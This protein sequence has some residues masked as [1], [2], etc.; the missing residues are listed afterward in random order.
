MFEALE[1][2]AASKSV[3]GD[4]ARAALKLAIGEDNA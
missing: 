1:F 2:Y 4:R 3:Y